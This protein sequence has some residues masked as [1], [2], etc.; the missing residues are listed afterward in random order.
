MEF[1]LLNG[2]G[3]QALEERAQEKDG[4][5]QDGEDVEDEELIMGSK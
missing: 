3:R 2:H 5:L 1:A 4:P